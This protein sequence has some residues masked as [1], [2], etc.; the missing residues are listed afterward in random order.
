MLDPDCSSC[1]L[2]Q[3]ECT[4]ATS[5]ASVRKLTHIKVVL[6]QVPCWRGP[7]ESEW[8]YKSLKGWNPLTTIIK[9]DMKASCEDVEAHSTNTYG[10]LV[11]PELCQTFLSPPIIT[12]VWCSWLVWATMRNEVRQLYT[13][14]KPVHLQGNKDIC[15][16]EKTLAKSLAYFLLVEWFLLYRKVRFRT[17]GPNLTFPSSIAHGIVDI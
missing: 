11:I 9:K 15:L 12:R 14:Y 3:N 16:W 13:G 2:L 10:S 1:Y 17:F 7:P 6:T 8:G 5:S 4:S